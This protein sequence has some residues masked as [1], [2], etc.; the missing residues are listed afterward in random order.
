MTVKLNQA[1]MY[2]AQSILTG[3]ANAVPR[4]QS[5]KAVDIMFSMNPCKTGT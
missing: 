3:A 1:E 2:Q 4:R 5:N